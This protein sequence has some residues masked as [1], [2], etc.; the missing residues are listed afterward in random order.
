M[1][2]QTTKKDPSNRYRKGLLELKNEL[3]SIWLG[4]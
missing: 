1:T 4:R 2:V 3:R